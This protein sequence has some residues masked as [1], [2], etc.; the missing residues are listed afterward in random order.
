LLESVELTGVD[1]ALL[2]HEVLAEQGLNAVLQ[3]EEVL[4]HESFFEAFGFEQKSVSH[5]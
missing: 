4:A 3:K 5:Q 1:L 2:L